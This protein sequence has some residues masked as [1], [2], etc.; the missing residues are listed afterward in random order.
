[1]LGNGI[2]GVYDVFYARARISPEHRIGFS[3]FPPKKL[4]RGTKSYII[5]FAVNKSK[6]LRLIYVIASFVVH[7]PSHVIAP[8]M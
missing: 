7:V 5:P 2:Q 3:V 8:R 1:M 4:Y 6:R